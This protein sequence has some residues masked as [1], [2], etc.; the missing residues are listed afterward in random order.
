[1]F[2]LHRRENVV[3][4]VAVTAAT[5]PDVD[6]QLEQLKEE[7]LQRLYTVQAYCRDTS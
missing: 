5:S 4:G 2:R 7:N 6:I 3:I 1:M